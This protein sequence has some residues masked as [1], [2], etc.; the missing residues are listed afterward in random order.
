VGKA[1][2]RAPLD[3]TSLLQTLSGRRYGAGLFERTED[4]ALGLSRLDA[5][6]VSSRGV[7]RTLAPPLK[8]LFVPE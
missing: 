7:D 6:A 1:S 5:M 4:V 8:E 2:T 3:T